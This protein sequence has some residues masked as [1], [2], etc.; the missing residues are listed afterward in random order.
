MAGVD[1][2][3]GD[4][5]HCTWGATGHLVC[6]LDGDLLLWFGY[7]DEWEWECEED[8]GDEED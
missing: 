2:Y 7:C 1:K 3:C 8:D 4:C 5:K 6:E